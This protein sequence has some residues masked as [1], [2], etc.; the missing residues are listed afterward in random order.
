MRHWSVYDGSAHPN[1]PRAHVLRAECACGWTD[2]SHP[3]DW[4]TA[5]GLR[6]REH[7]AETAGRCLNDWDQHTMAVATTTVPVPVELE[8]LLESV[9]AAIE[10]LAKESPAAAVKAA[11]TLEIIA[12]RTAYWPAREAAAEDPE[13]VAAALGLNVE[14]TRRLLARFGGFSPYH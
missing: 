1:R 6:F 9:T 3:V 12:Q 8:V 5:G 10:D 11:R 14:E 13:K 7:G 4:E 2:E